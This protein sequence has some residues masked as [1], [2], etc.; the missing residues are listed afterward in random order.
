MGLAVDA[1]MKVLLRQKS[2]PVETDNAEGRLRASRTGELF[3]ANWKQSLVM[4]GKVWRVTAGTMIAGGDVS[5]VT[6]G[7][8]GTIIDQDQPEVAIGVPSGFFLIPLE[9]RVSCQVDLDADGEVGNIIAA[10][11]RSGGVPASVTGVLSSA[12][13]GR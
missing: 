3:T 13:R 8:D 7:G 2:V 9:I 11:D 12:K 10:V 6:G 5:L 1:L 4:Q